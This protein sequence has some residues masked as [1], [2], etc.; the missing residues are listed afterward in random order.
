MSEI[1]THVLDTSRGSPA[2]GF[3][4]GLQLKSGDAWKT[5]GSGRTDGNGR[6]RGL[7]GENQLE[8]GTYRLLF[9]AGDYYRELGVE[10]FYS[11]IP[12][13]F[14]VANPETHYHVPLLINPFGYST[15][16]GS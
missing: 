9:N 15:Y 12:I 1:T 7:L 2:A 5:L 8:A 4:V 16:R 14:E 10:T 3:Q 11:E 6:C 13:V